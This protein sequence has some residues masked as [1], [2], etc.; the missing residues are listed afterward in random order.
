[1]NGK[2]DTDRYIA[3]EASHV[4]SVSCTPLPVD[5]GS[6][7]GV[8][9][10]TVIENREHCRALSAKKSET[11]TPIFLVVLHAGSEIGKIEI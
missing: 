7:G 4:Q 3:A 11:I 5:N 1:M 10:H 9:V 8:P 2:L 6:L